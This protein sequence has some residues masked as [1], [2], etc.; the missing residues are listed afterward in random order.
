M[1]LIII[2]SLSLVILLSSLI[3][4]M[5]A[6]RK[7]SKKMDLIDDSFDKKIHKMMT[8]QNNVYQKTTSH[9]NEKTLEL[10]KFIHDNLTRSLDIYNNKIIELQNL[11]QKEFD[12]TTKEIIFTKD[13][14]EKLLDKFQ[15]DIVFAK[16]EAKSSRVE[17]QK[18][19]NKML[20]DFNKEILEHKA[21]SLQ[22]KKHIEEQLVSILNEIK[23]PLDLNY[24]EKK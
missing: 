17:F 21:E 10:N 12:S 15:Q 23:S 20:D 14:T 16:T 18:D 24:N 5:L 13:K 11:I 8:E 3:L 4:N 6:N 2:S 22:L 7:L 9:F 19:L 1:E